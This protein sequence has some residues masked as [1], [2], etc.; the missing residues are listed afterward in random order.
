MRYNNTTIGQMV[1]DVYNPGLECV[2]GLNLLDELIE[3]SGLGKDPKYVEAINMIL[4][5][6]HATQDVGCEMIYA[7]CERDMVIESVKEH[8]VGK[9]LVKKTMKELEL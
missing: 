8:A 6:L 2:K 5:G 1:Q 3:K 4:N 7:I 9:R